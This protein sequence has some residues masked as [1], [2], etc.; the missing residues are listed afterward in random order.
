MQEQTTDDPGRP[1][2]PFDEPIYTVKEAGRILKLS[3]N[4]VTKMFENE[5]GVMDIAPVQ[6]FGKRRK[7]MLR[8]PH[9]VVVRVCKRSEVQPKKTHQL[10][11][12][13]SSN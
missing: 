7:R 1:A 10:R 13:I 2:P 3:D 12:T 8:I 9:S 11:R 6:F 4:E 5:P